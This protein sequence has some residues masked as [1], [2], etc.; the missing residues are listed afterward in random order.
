MALLD[1][2]PETDVSFYNN[3]LVTAD[4]DSKS[5]STSGQTPT[6]SEHLS[7]RRQSLHEEFSALVHVPELA[8]QRVT[9]AT[10]EDVLSSSSNY[11][12]C[13]FSCTVVLPHCTHVAIRL[14]GCHIM[15]AV[16]SYKGY[17]LP[18]CQLIM[19]HS[20]PKSRLLNVEILP[21]LCLISPINY[22]Y[23]IIIFVTVQKSKRLLCTVVII[24]NV[25]VSTKLI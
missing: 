1:I 11:M 8:T 5:S 15:P 3:V 24:M 6:R 13:G 25:Q 20:L 17:S 19:I 21:L 18:Y 22:Y 23:I 7:L 10:D 9:Q 4:G 12:V 2:E 14:M 16:I